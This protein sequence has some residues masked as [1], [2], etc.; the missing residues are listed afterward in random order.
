MNSLP[1]L[2]ETAAILLS[3]RVAES[4]K[5]P[6]RYQSRCPACA[7]HFVPFDSPLLRRLAFPYSLLSA[8]GVTKH[9]MDQYAR[10][11]I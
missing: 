9:A 10:V 7:F 4:E 2:S 5:R 11:D 1:F 3:A 6:P 8:K